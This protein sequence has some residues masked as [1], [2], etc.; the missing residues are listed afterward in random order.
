MRLEARDRLLLLLFVPL[1]LGVGALHVKEIRR[2]GI[3]QPPVFAVP[4]H[5]GGY[6]TVGSVRL[7]RGSD[8]GQ[9]RV[10]DELR[11]IGDVD[12]RGV[13]Y[14]GFDAIALEQAGTQLVAPLVYGRDGETHEVEMRMVPYQRPWHRL[15]GAIGLALIATAVLLRSRNRGEAR[16]FFVGAMSIVVIVLPFI[17]GPRWQTYAHCILFNFFGWLALALMLRWAIFF[18]GLKQADRLPSGLMWFALLHLAVR[19]NYVLGG[20]LPPAAVPVAALI[21][22]GAFAALLLFILTRNYFH[23]DPTGRRQIKWLIAGAHVALSPLLLGLLGVWLG[24][25]SVAQIMQTVFPAATIALPV[26]LGFGVVRYNLFD[27]DRFLSASAS[28][29]AVGALLVVGLYG[30]TSP[31]TRFL[32]DWPGLPLG[33]AQLIASALV[34]ATAFALHSRIRPRIE[35]ALFPERQHTQ[36]QVGGLIRELMR[37]RTQLDVGR[38][39]TDRLPGIFQLELVKS[40]DVCPDDESIDSLP[41]SARTDLARRQVPLRLLDSSGQRVARYKSIDSGLAVLLP[42]L[43][44][45][46]LVGAIGLG[47]PRHGDVFTATDL[48][49]LT[50]V[51]S[52]ASSAIKGSRDATEIAAHRQRADQLDALRARAEGASEQK[53]RSLA[54]ASHELRQ[55]VHALALTIDGLAEHSPEDEQL[56]AAQ[57]L[58]STVVGM[59]ESILDRSRLE[60]GTIHPDVHP[61]DV[62]AMLI[63]TQSEFEAAASRKHLEMKVSLS[64]TTLTASSDPSLLRR[65]VR[66][67]VSNA[68]KYTE[69]GQVT[70]EAGREGDRIRIT[71]ADTGAGIPPDR[72]TAI[73]DEFVR[74]D[75]G[76]EGVGLGLAIV[77][78]L[79]ELL[80]IE[81]ALESQPGLGS[82]FSLIVPAAEAQAGLAELRPALAASQFLDL[83]VL[84]VDDIESVRRSVGRILEG[85]GCS[86][87]TADGFSETKSILANWEPEIVLADYWLSSEHD[88]LDVI[89]LVERRTSSYVGTAIITGERDESALSR[90]RARRIPVLEKPARVNR[91]RALMTSLQKEVERRRP[92]SVAAP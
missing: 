38:V 74:L 10:G 69:D 5:D 73:F 77:K 52:A 43:E 83:K 15:P 76:S 72:Q 61:V 7:E 54:V 31:A 23:T 55:P 18:P 2:T 90:V 89:E 62:Q 27:V 3:P 71:I 42:L 1:V 40:W 92:R 87:Q 21:V 85:W 6:P 70:I 14:I 37:C 4:S 24:Y 67:L 64:G 28:Y 86:V 20:P 34:G 58:V 46:E 48:A 8:R 25:L 12:L 63:E 29:T 81:L 68:I 39:L 36:D 26:A 33:T 44:G 59:F 11:R 35:R 47:R 79:C 88:G 16:R 41:S 19:A 50:S 13:G 84:V 9:L 91:L 75:T 66:N 80:E 22:D 60:A 82:R 30:V 56:Q 53:S 45:D 32:V 49:H 57:E 78:Q 17:G 51:I 65:V